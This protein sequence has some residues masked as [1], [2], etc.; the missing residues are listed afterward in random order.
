MALSI[1]EVKRMLPAGVV[2]DE[3]DGV[4]ALTVKIKGAGP[5]IGML[6]GGLAAGAYAALEVPDLALQIFAVP[7]IVGAFFGF[8]LLIG[9]RR[10][11]IDGNALRVRT[12]PFPVLG[13]G[14]TSSDAIDAIEV[15]V[16]G[17][18]SGITSH[19]IDVVTRG[20]RKHLVH[21]LE[22][23]QALVLGRYLAQELRV[24][25]PKRAVQLP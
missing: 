24:T 21:D 18:K 8:S 4:P 25:P 9:K 20:K 19:R 6:L 7:A 16:V 17:Q 11:I 5:G 22:E 15:I 1:A 14:S 2:L 10:V 12:V 13:D 3:V 23:E